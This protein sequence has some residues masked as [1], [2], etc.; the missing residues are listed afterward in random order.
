MDEDDSL[1]SDWDEETIA[2]LLLASTNDEVPLTTGNEEADL[3]AVIAV[4][5]KQKS[6]REV[7]L[8]I[9]NKRLNRQLELNG[10][11]RQAVYADGNCFFKAASLHI[12]AHD[13][14]SLREAL[15]EHIVQHIETY[16]GFFPD[17]S[18]DDVIRDVSRMKLSGVWN[19]KTND[20]LPL[21]LANL[22]GRRL[23]IFTSK[24]KP[25]MFDVIPT[26]PYVK[27]DAFSPIYVAKLAPNGLPEHYDGCLAKNRHIFQM[28]G[29]VPHP[30][31]RHTPSH[32]ATTPLGPSATTSVDPDATTSL[33]PGATKSLDPGA[34]TSLDPDAELP[35]C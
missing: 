2:A 11:E 10:M 12:P 29:S 15:C 7:A 9:H 32:E 33:D 16:V 20:A 26:L 27:R 6:L 17:S 23:K 14:V 18:A 34:T 21:A 8:N 31:T 30:V 4:S 5:K 35:T 3:A 1:W 24:E 19:L 13:E 22:T 28:F 25:A